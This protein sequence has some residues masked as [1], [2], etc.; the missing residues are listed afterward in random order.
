MDIHVHAL[1]CLRTLQTHI[2]TQPAYCK[3]AY[4]AC[5]PGSVWMKIVATH[6]RAGVQHDGFAYVCREKRGDTVHFAQHRTH[7]GET[8]S[9]RWWTLRGRLRNVGV[10]VSEL[11][12]FSIRRNGYTEY[13]MSGCEAMSRVCRRMAD[14]CSAAADVLGRM[15]FS[16]SSP[17]AERVAEQL[18]SALVSH[19][20]EYSDSR[21][22]ASVFKV[23]P[24]MACHV[25]MCVPSLLSGKLSMNPHFVREM[26]DRHS[27]LSETS[28]ML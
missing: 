1:E 14:N 12:H 23:D 26:R 2:L 10:N 13:L 21:L 19:Y 5:V 8:E 6:E 22:L 25:A 11:H 20:S 16:E 3:A 9:D 17:S 28:H 27:L 15:T 18:R 24:D 4:G 7:L